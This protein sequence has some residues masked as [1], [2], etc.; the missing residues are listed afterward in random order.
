[1]IR[2]TLT[3]VA[4]ALALAACN[5]TTQLVGKSYGV[6]EPQNAHAAPYHCVSP[7]WGLRIV[8]TKEAKN[9]VTD[10]PMLVKAD[11]YLCVDEAT[12]KKYPVGTSYP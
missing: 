9:P 2:G 11:H 5:E 12:A 7:K 8:S 4:A 3:L 6:V 10:Q 1:M